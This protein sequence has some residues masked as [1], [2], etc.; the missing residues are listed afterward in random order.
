M[1]NIAVFC[2]CI[3]TGQPLGRVQGHVKTQLI[4]HDKEVL[5]MIFY[6]CS[7]CLC[8]AVFGVLRVCG[9]CMS[10]MWCVVCGV[11]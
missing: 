9:M 11:L 6:V 3:Q 5:I 1:N 2:F 8:V 4:A 10:G 7:L